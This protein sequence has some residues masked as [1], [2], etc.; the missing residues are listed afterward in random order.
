MGSMKLFRIH[1]A[2]A[3]LLYCGVAASQEIASINPDF[4]DAGFGDP[5]S[6]VHA[7]FL[8]DLL[9]LSDEQRKQLSRITHELEDSL[10]PL[11]LEALQ[12]QLELEREF[13]TGSPDQT[14]VTVIA[15]DFERIEGQFNG[16]LEEHRNMARAILGW[17]Q[18]IVL[19]KLEVALELYQAAREAVDLNLVAGPDLGRMNA[20]VGRVRTVSR[21]A[22]LLARQQILERPLEPQR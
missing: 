12:K 16:V 13:R 9:S 3:A 5:A 10:F 7:P 18:L 11:T 14:T 20:D 19:G 17:D 21:F 22:W 4:V 15:T 2:L 8:Q 6:S 1:F